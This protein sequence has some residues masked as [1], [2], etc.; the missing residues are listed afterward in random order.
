MFR[1]GLTASETYQQLK[2]ECGLTSHQI[3]SAQNVAEMLYKRQLEADKYLK[4]K[5]EGSIKARKAATTSGKRGLTS[6]KKQLASQQALA[7]AQSPSKT[8]KRLK[9]YVECL[10]KIRTLSQKVNKK[11]NWLKMK[12][13]GLEHKQR[14]LARLSARLDEKRVSICF[15]SRKLLAQNPI[16]NK[17]SDFES[18][19]SWRA[20]WDLRRNNQIV[21]IGKKDKPHG[22]AE[23]Q[24][25]PEG[26]TLRL[27]LTD[28][29]AL[30][31]MNALADETGLDIINGKSPKCCNLR[32][33]ARFLE[34]NGVD[35]TGHKDADTGISKAQF[36]LEQFQGKLP[37]T[38]KIVHRKD[39]EDSKFY[40]QISLDT[41]QTEEFATKDRGVMGLDFNAKGVAWSVVKPD[42]NLLS[43]QQGFISWNLH[44]HPS[45]S[46][47]VQLGT[48]AKQLAKIST[49]HDVAIA[50]ENLDFSDAKFKSTANY[51]DEKGRKFNATLS[52]LASSQFQ[53]LIQKNCVENSIGLYFVNPCYSSVGGFAKYGYL[54]RATVDEAASHWIARQALYGESYKRKLMAPNEFGVKLYKESLRL[55]GLPYSPNQRKKAEVSPE[56]KSVASALGNYR[57]LWS[58][59]LREFIELEVANAP[60]SA[61][62]QEALEPYQREQG[63]RLEAQH[64]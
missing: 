37:M 48:I 49:K 41:P 62:L 40:L 61:V 27:R 8:G 29:Q 32:M 17:A 46:I 34:I 26:K 43:G 12:E 64:H 45:G 33:Q 21:S 10:A 19:E 13:S 59:K 63:R 20:E 18:Y 55:H 16:N 57:F 25:N 38:A 54:T 7:L 23:I 9:A 31:R 15:G 52:S 28:E 47:A 2:S 5:I 56:W 36:L 11:S 42:G 24:W 39:A 35:F 3:G 22:N 50:I 30:V 4:S 58:R 44:K 14:Q 1:D 53:A 51:V 6:L 60:P